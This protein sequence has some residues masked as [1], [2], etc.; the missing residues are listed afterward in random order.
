[1]AQLRT[2]NTVENRHRHHGEDSS[3]KSKHCVE[4]IAFTDFR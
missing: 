2:L 3:E 1:M 4:N